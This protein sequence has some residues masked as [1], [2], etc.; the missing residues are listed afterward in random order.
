MASPGGDQISGNA[1]PT[2]GQA[3]SRDRGEY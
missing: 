1:D 3:S 2:F